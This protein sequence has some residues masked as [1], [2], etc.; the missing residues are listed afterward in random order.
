MNVAIA[1]QPIK[2]PTIAKGIIIK[3]RSISPG[4]FK[5]PL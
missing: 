4:F 1:K 5:R 2:A 3:S